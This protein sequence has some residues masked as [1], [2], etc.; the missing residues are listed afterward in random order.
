MLVALVACQQGSHPRL[1]SDADIAAME[2]Q[3]LAHVAE[4]PR[5]CVNNELVAL[6][7]YDKECAQNASEIEYGKHPDMKMDRR[8]AERLAQLVR[9]AKEGCSPLQVGMAAPIEDTVVEMWPL[10]VARMLTRHARAEPDKY[11]AIADLLDV[12]AAMHSLRRGYVYLVTNTIAVGAEAKV[13]DAINQLLSNAKL[14][15]DQLDDLSGRINGLIATEPPVLD[16]L[17]GEFRTMELY[18]GLAPLRPKWIPPGGKAGMLGMAPADHHNPMD[19][20]ALM[21]AIGLER[22]ETV[23]RICTTTLAACD[24]ELRKFP[25]ETPAYGAVD[26]AVAEYQANPSEEARERC[27]RELIRS[28]GSLHV[29]RYYVEQRA[30]GVVRLTALRMQL[31]AM[32]SGTCPAPVAPTVLGETVRV[33]RNGDGIDVLPPTWVD[34]PKTVARISCP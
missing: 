26:R 21:M 8:C 10:N 13:V 12:V 18:Y 4:T 23:K 22:E 1:F 32:R 31:D 11:D 28:L 7:T 15:S 29:F 6:F 20:Q 3:V 27:K 25:S 24:A 30:V 17:L 33:V 2:V 34:K 19:D 5:D 9:H 14:S 16:M